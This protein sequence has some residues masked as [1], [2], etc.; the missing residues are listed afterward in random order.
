MHPGSCIASQLTKC[1]RNF[2]HKFHIILLALSTLMKENETKSLP[3]GY[4]RAMQY[5]LALAIALL[6]V[7]VY[8]SSIASER[9]RKI[10]PPARFDS[11]TGRGTNCP[12]LTARNSIFSKSQRAIQR[13]LTMRRP[14]RRTSQRRVSFR[15]AS[16][17]V[18]ATNPST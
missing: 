1:Q 5:A 18:L 6:V 17:I 14:F 8:R 13:Y 11:A 16:Q 10:P 7:V 9:K 4:L 15:R 2:R 12:A 3:E